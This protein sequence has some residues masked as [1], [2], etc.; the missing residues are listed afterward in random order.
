[1]RRMLGTFRNDTLTAY[2]RAVEQP[3]PTSN[4]LVRSTPATSAPGH[5]MSG[6]SFTAESGHHSARARST[7]PGRRLRDRSMWRTPHTICVTTS[8]RSRSASDSPSRCFR[9][10]SAASP[11]W[12]PGAA[13]GQLKGDGDDRSRTVTAV[14]PQWASADRVLAADLGARADGR[15]EGCEG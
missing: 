4:A 8:P 15:S 2:E 14:R 9:L 6:L 3:E 13:Q 7:Q 1:M 12:K 11:Q 10:C 5:H